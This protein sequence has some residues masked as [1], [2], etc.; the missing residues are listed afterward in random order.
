MNKKESSVADA[1]KNKLPDN[2][3]DFEKQSKKAQN[4]ALEKELEQFEREMEAL[5]AESE[6]KLKEEFERIQ[7]EKDLDE[8]DTRIDQWKRIIELEK[9]AEELKNKPI[10]ES[11]AKK[12]KLSTEKQHEPDLDTE[13]IEEFEDKMFNWRSKKL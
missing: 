12:L 8:L 11:S 5:Q 2:F 6:E 1:N 9:R 13:D 4:D 7:D 10:S 3:F